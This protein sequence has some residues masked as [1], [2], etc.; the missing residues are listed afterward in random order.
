MSPIRVLVCDDHFMVRQ[1]LSTYFELQD[2][3]EVI[4]EAGNGQEAVAKAKALRPDVVLMDLIMPELDGLGALEVLKGT[5]IRVII[6]TSF[7]DSEK[8]LACIEAG[9][10]GFLTKDIQPADLVDAIR[11]V[12]RGEP[13]L[14][15]EVTKRLMTR[16]LH[17]QQPAGKESLTARELDVLRCL[18]NGMTNREIA[19]KLVI[20]ETT[21]KTHISSILSK[22]HLTDRTQAALFAVREKLLD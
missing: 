12:H 13:R 4:G 8:A 20:S 15:P 7:L 21:V 2:D 5:G 19:E 1:G 14:H 3:F 22:L 10:M 16:A 18:A 9:A 11:A 17:P 6:L